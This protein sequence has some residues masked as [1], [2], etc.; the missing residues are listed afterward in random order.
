MVEAICRT[1]G[2]GQRCIVEVDLT[3]LTNETV[4]RNVS[5]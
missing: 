1:E 3:E 5:K 2:V 4:K